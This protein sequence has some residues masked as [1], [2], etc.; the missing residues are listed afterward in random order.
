MIKTKDKKRKLATIYEINFM[1]D[2]SEE[3]IKTTSY[4]DIDITKPQLIIKTSNN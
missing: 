4:T 1:V 3:H 2:F